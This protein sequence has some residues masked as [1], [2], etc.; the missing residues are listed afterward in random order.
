[1]ILEFHPAVQQDFNHAIAYYEAE[2][3]IHLADRFEA[4]FRASLAAIKS[5]PRTIRISRRVPVTAAF[6]LKTFPTSF[7]IKNAP[8]TSASLC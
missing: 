1:M 4:E 7:F 6:G 2:G 5:G 3:G 8:A